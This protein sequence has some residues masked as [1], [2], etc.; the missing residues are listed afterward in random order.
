MIEVI[1][2]GIEYKCVNRGHEM[3]LLKTS[4]GWEM[5]TSNASVWA[6][7][8]SGASFFYTLSEV[9]ARYKSWQGIKALTELSREANH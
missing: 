6:W 8:T 5:Y 9:E 7:R 3:T 4:F 2:E 1:R